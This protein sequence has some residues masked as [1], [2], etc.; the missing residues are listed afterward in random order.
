M[1]ILDLIDSKTLQ[2]IQDMF[3]DATGLAAIAIDDK[4][5]YITEGSNFTDF[6]MKYT[7][8][9]KVGKQRCEKCDAECTGTYFCHAGLMDFS[10]DIVV[11]GEKLG[12]IIGGQ[13][14]PE[15]PNDEKFRG[16]A[17]ELG[18][19]AEEY[20]QAVHKVPVKTEQAIRASAKLLGEVV[21]T[22][23]NMKY[24]ESKDKT[25]LRI[26]DEEMGRAVEIT[27]EINEKTRQL[28]R[29]ASQ[30][31]ILALNATIEAARVGDS[32]VGF[33]VVAQQM[34]VLSKDSQEI[35]EKISDSAEEISGAIEKMN[36]SLK[37]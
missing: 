24:M 22:L 14:L 7:R 31:T 29:I 23:V 26:I 36:Q 4:G 21:N 27:E 2:A 5:E 28:N 30:Q 6:C 8:E 3:S 34:G 32:G 1:K 18:V 25:V 19:D 17:E 9:T 13:V 11:E 33:A 16:I 20:I 12:A 10:T 37:R 35:Y 15:A